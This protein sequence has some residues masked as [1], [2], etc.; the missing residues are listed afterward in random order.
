MHYVRIID[1]DSLFVEDAFVEELTAFTIETPCPEGLN[2]PKW[3]GSE[4]VEGG[5]APVLEPTL[6]TDIEVLR[7][8]IKAS[9]ARADFLEEVIV[10]MAMLIYE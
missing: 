2:R 7:A 3:T 6:P 1:K 5:E 10:E 4:W 8:Q 9:D